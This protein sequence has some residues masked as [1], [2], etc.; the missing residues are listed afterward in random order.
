MFPLFET[1]KSSTQVGFFSRHKAFLRPIC[2]MDM[3]AFQGGYLKIQKVASTCLPPP[4]QQ[5]QQHSHRTP[6][7]SFP[8]WHPSSLPYHAL[9]SHGFCVACLLEGTKVSNLLSTLKFITPHVRCCL[10]A[11]SIFVALPIRTSL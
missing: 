2:A 1:S 7:I 6:F 5:Q 8:S 4:H 9:S 10:L 11:F 3:L